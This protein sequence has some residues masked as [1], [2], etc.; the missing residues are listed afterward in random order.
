MGG[1]D[2]SNLGQHLFKMDEQKRLE[3]TE[4]KIGQ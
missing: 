3:V 4:K 1:W 2:R